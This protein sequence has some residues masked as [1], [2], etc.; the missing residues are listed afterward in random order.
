MVPVACASL[1]SCAHTRPKQ[2]FPRIGDQS[3]MPLQNI[4]QLVLSRMGVPDCRGP[5]GGKP[6]EINAEIGQ[7]EQVAERTLFTLAY[8]GGEW[9]GVN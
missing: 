4:D 1:E 8:A 2:S 9:L 6:G 7:A 5:A 3:R